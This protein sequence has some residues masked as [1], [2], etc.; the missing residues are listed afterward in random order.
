MKANE[1]DGPT[2][3]ENYRNYIKKVFHDFFILFIK[4]D[5]T[6]MEPLV[7]KTVTQF[8]QR[9]TLFTYPLLARFVIN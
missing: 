7:C 4:S 8:F 5:D 9:V 6:K 1:A 3:N 2:N